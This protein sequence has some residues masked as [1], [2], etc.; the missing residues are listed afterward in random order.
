M[1]TIIDYG[2]GN[3]RSVQKAFERIRVKAIITSREDDILNADKIILPGVGHFERGFANL[4]KLGIFEILNSAVIEK[5]IPILGICLGMQLMTEYSEEG[6]CEGLGWIKGKTRKF[7]FQIKKLKIPHMGWNNLNIKREN[8]LTHNIDNNDFFYFVH[9]YFVTCD[10]ENDI[11][12]ETSYGERF[13]SSFQ[14]DNIYGCQFHPEKSHDAGLQ[15][16]RNFAE[17]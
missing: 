9:S 2:M 5:K 11:I 6:N 14:R 12:S 10:D 8:N 15:V 3:L 7:N 4:K 13:V 1:I 16:L 17:I